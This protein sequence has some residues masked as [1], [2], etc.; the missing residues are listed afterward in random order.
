MGLLALGSDDKPEEK[1]HEDSRSVSME[2]GGV[3]ESDGLCMG[4]ASRCFPPQT[5]E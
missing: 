1:K 2:L 4:D 5:N 3:W